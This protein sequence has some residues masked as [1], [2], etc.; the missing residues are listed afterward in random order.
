VKLPEQV[1]KLA[2]K[3]DAMTLRERALVFAAVA[4][5]L[6]SL[7]NSLFIEPQLAKQKKLSAQIVQQQEKMKAVEAQIATLVQARQSDGHSPQGARIQAL[8]Q[9]IAEGNAYLKSR[10]DKLVPPEK[11]AQLLEQV[12]NR[13]KHLTLVA[14]DTLPV[15]PL[16]EP[17][18]NQAAAR[19][20]E[21]GSE[22]YKHGVTI[23][24]RGSYAALL[25]Y[26]TALEKLPTQMY[27]GVAKMSVVKYPTTEL[28][29]TLYTLS[30]DRTW[31]QV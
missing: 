26:L 9:Q 15:S 23:T 6:V 4:F 14:L 29:L 3:V 30:L 25:Q 10:R 27:W 11:M 1:A 2:A 13:N 21:A 19:K 16:I 8:R 31:L 17:S 20:T 5:L 22:I 7:I 24:V 12:L 28:T 18:G